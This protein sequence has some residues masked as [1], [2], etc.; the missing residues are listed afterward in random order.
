LNDV[1]K[2]Q[3]QLAQLSYDLVLLE[4]LR[5]TEVTKL[6]TLLNRDPETPL[7]ELG[8]EPL[9]SMAFSIEEL[10]SLAREH[11]EELKVADLE[12]EKSMKAMDL[13]GKASL[14]DFTLGFSYLDVGESSIAGLPDSG[15][16]A[17]GLSLGVSLPIWFKK[18]RA[19]EREA[20]LNYLRARELKDARLNDTYAN[21]K[22]I[23]FKLTNADR[24]V[25]LYMESLIPQSEE[26]LEIAETWYRE[27]KG[28][29]SDLLETQSVWLNFNLA[30]YRAV[31]DYQQHLARL[32]GL[33]GVSLQEPVRR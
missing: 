17:Y 18:N 9:S 3:A 13:A 28:S 33:V 23:Y 26:S 2:A 24:L 8:D 30:Y 31:S 12:I 14:P 11:Q 16:D 21:V 1:L 20:R 5:Q 10:Y 32:E 7:G 25:R 19:A 29:F 27:G 4:E 6:N 15:K 22:N